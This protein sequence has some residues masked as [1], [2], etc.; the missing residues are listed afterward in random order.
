[1]MSQKRNK[2]IKMNPEKN[3]QETPKAEVE[4]LNPEARIS[5]LEAE[6]SEL[7]DKYL[8]VMAEFE[9]LPASAA[10]RK[11]QIGFKIGNAE[12]LALEILRCGG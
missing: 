10:L 8:R 2:D 9:E 12:P 1:M 4:E 11:S 7:N 3:K 5:E 6:V